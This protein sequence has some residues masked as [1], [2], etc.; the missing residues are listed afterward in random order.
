MKSSA[1]LNQAFKHPFAKPAKR[2]LVFRDPV[3]H[4]QL[5]GTTLSLNVLFKGTVKSNRKGKGKGKSWKGRKLKEEF[6]L[7]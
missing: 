5:K 1:T 6:P 7:A 3:F 2:E 4:L